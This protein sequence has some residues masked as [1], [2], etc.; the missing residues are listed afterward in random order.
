MHRWFLFLFL[1]AIALVHAEPL[2]PSV[3][4]AL[5]QAD[6]PQS[7]VG[8]YVREL[9]SAKPDIAHRPDLPMHT[10]RMAVDIEDEEA[11]PVIDSGPGIDEKP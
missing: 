10:E 3:V 7:A 9:G 5:Q 1:G 2:P 4:K 8:I 11:D 6:I